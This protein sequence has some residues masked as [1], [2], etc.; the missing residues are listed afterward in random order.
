MKAGSEV[1]SGGRQSKIDLPARPRVSK[2]DV[3]IGR[4]VDGIA[5]CFGNDRFWSHEWMKRAWIARPG[6]EESIGI[7][8]VALNHIVAIY[9]R[10]TLES[11]VAR[12]AAS[13]ISGDFDRHGILDMNIS[14]RDV[15]RPINTNWGGEPAAVDLDRRVAIGLNRVS[16]GNSL[17]IA[18][19][20][21][22]SS[23][24][25]LDKFSRAFASK[26]AHAGIRAT[27]IEIEG[28]DRS[29]ATQDSHA[30]TAAAIFYARNAIGGDLELIQAAINAA[31]PSLG[32]INRDFPLRP[33][34]TLASS[35]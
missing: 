9:Q 19:S 15:S 20:N 7:R 33:I 1:G 35:D 22:Q 3:G 25:K 6:G 17:S 32:A 24:V 5:G 23:P 27:E 4:A 21:A 12:T 34:M 18:V 8:P 11:V 2:G 13:G 30:A 31:N 26:T 10:D 16:A 29:R 28:V 14:Q